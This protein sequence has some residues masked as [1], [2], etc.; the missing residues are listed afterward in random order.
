MTTGLCG[1]IGVTFLNIKHNAIQ[2]SC[3][4]DQIL[5]L[6]HLSQLHVIGE[7]IACSVAMVMMSLLGNPV[8]AHPSHRIILLA[9][10]FLANRNVSLSIVVLR[11]APVRSL[12]RIYSN[13]GWYASIVSKL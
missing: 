2:R 13:A 11:T 7:W 3:D 6:R 12:T 5:M 4:L 9:K 1:F 10:F 8:C